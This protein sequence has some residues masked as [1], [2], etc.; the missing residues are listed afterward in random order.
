MKVLL[1]NGSRR[2]NGCT[3]TALTKVADVLNSN[4]IETE[5]FNVGRRIF[6]GEIEAVV[7]E[8]AEKVKSADGF[9][10]GTPV[11]YASPSGEV[12]S[13]LDRLFNAS[14]GDLRFKPA[15][16]IASCRR[17]GTVSSLDVL[18]KY[19]S[20]NSMPIVTSRYW[21][22]VHG[23][24]PE[25]VLKDKEGLQIL[26]I[27]GKNMTWLLKSIEAGKSN[28]VTQPVSEE[29]IFTNFISN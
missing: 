21:N 9:V 10:V 28:G 5:I 6:N 3:F 12:I 18:N 7:S 2:D 26:E 20:F 22:E 15:A 29:K 19:F 23:K 24:N 27:L 17:A 8:A 14:E 1:I 4:N 11:Y 16:A 13:F 25:D